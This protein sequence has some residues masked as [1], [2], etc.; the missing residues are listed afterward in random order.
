MKYRLTD[1][2]KVSHDGQIL[3]QIQALRSFKIMDGSEVSAGEY[4]GWIEGPQNLSQNGNCWVANDACV[5]GDAFVYDNALI[6]NT[7]IVCGSS[8]VYE[9]AVIFHS[10]IIKECADIR[11]ESRISGCSVVCGFTQVSGSTIIKDY[12]VVDGKT[13]IA[14]DGIV[15]AHATI[16]STSTATIYGVVSGNVK[17]FGEVFISDTASVSGNVVLDGKIN[18]VDGT[19]IYSEREKVIND[20]TIFN[21]NHYPIYISK[22][23]FALNSKYKIVPIHYPQESL[24]PTPS[25]SIYD[26]I[27]SVVTDVF[28]DNINNKMFP[29]LKQAYI[30]SQDELSWLLQETELD[31]TK[32]KEIFSILSYFAKIDNPEVIISRLRLE[33]TN[34]LIKLS[35]VKEGTSILSNGHIIAMTLNEYIYAQFLGIILFGIS[36]CNKYKEDSHKIEIEPKWLCFVNNILNNSNINISNKE[37]SDINEITFVYNKEMISAVAHIC[38]F[39]N[40]WETETLKKLKATKASALELYC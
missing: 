6:C 24:M 1:K 25:V 17:I 40:D 5:Y 26:K 12:A 23:I 20:H 30:Y 33:F 36:I 4:G 8:R 18:I 16:D 32:E 19:Y 31:I 2:T 14:R 37:I 28:E 38:G 34:Q 11:G 15:S 21:K 22:E 13:T 9:N 39:S 27:V 3:Y 35:K 10:A 7:A 29:S